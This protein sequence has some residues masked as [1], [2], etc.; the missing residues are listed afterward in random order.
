MVSQK[1]SWP[2]TPSVLKHPVEAEPLQEDSREGGR[3][4][5][6]ASMFAAF[7]KAHCHLLA[8]SI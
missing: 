1:G 3:R 8:Q 6:E 2:V 4:T 7:C 5:E